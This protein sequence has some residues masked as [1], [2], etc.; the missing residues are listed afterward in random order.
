MGNCCIK[1]PAVDPFEA[2]ASAQKDRLV[3]SVV[4]TDLERDISTK[5][6]FLKD[7]KRDDDDVKELSTRE[8]SKLDRYQRFEKYFPFYRMDV[9]GYQALLKTAR[10]NTHVG[11]EPPMMEY[12]IKDIGYS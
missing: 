2:D 3:D 9:N 10:I 12:E 11:K 1:K 8:L 4:T 7:S 5:K 6:E